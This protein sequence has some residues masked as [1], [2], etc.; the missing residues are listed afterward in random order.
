MVLLF[1]SYIV[2][3]LSVLKPGTIRRGHETYS[4]QQLLVKGL[5][6]PNFAGSPLVF[7]KISPAGTPQFENSSHDLVVCGGKEDLKNL[8]VVLCLKLWG[9]YFKG[10]RIL[11]FFL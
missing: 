9:R 3:N 11:L 7:K 5:T 10:Q 4:N 8:S 2:G 6:C 1:S